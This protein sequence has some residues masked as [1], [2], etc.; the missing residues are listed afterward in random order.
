MNDNFEK[1]LTAVS[2]MK[3]LFKH[4]TISSPPKPVG[5]WIL[6]GNG[7]HTQFPMWVKP[8]P[9]HIENHRV[10]LGWIWRNAE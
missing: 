8:T 9:E 10:M 3:D 4:A 2:D 1:E 6:G 5:Y 7:Y